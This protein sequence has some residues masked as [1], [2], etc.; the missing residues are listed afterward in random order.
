VDTAAVT[1]EDIVIQKIG[2]KKNDLLFRNRNR[3]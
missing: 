2:G 1:A 3:Y